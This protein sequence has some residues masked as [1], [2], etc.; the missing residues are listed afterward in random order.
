MRK[1]YL[2]KAVALA[3]AVTLAAGMTLTGCGKKKVDYDMGDGEDGTATE[4]GKLS[5]KL[6]V[7][8]SY[9][10]TLEGIDAATG[11]GKVSFNV[12]EVF[13][14]ETDKMSIYYYENNGVDNEY[15]KRVCESFLD[16]NAGIYVYNWDKPY[17]GDIEREIERLNEMSAAS[18][19]DEEKSWYDE[20]L[21][22]L[23]DQLKDAT[24]ERE[25]AGDYSGEAFV[26]S[27][28]E[29][30]YMIS[31]M[32]SDDGSNG[33]F[34]IDYYPGDQLIS[35][36]P[37]DGAT[38][39][40]YYSADYGYDTSV[41][42]TENMSAMSADEAAQKGLDFLA[43]CGITDVVMTNT[44][45]LLWEYSDNNYNTIATEKEGYVVTY[46]RSVEGVAP[47]TPSI[48]Q[49]DTL[50]SDEDV[51][52]DSQDESFEISID[53]KG[54]V[55]AYCYDLFR[56]T[57]EK[58]ENV[59]LISWDEALKAL[60]A[61]MNEYYTAHKTNYSAIEF[62]DARLSY[63]KIMDGDKFKYTPVWSFA[64]CE[65]GT[66]GLPDDQSIVQLIMLDA[67]TGKLID[68]TKVLKSES[69]GTDGMDSSIVMEDDESSDGELD[70]EVDEEFDE[71]S[72]DDVMIDDVSDD[73]IEIN[74]DDLG[75]D[76]IKD[77]SSDNEEEA[78]EE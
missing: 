12:S 62:N 48:Y 7:P 33:G 58:E 68:F 55:G 76:M 75:E 22:E 73:E 72:T 13:V 67:V 77:D 21:Q 11:I 41:A 59:K 74:L 42:D 20:Y 47:Y 26:G 57:G 40:Y 15:K 4:G 28:G 27:K 43:S 66:D 18:T 52:Y 25:G 53:D 64:Q 31:F 32:S 24:D 45:D 63:Y 39:L 37:K 50:N 10:G 65:I 51:W 16:V 17:K 9:Q 69:Y 36:R 78:V 44:S 2:K 60:P 23:K 61:A 46:K 3:L 30:M 54:I 8:E 71:D 29:D 6:E 56:P 49:L 70:E 1:T 38:N 34:Y 5:S 35:Y 19:S 14:P